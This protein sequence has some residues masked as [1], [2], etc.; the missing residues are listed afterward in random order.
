MKK[1]YEHD[2]KEMS[3]VIWICRP[4]GD[5]IVDVAVFLKKKS[6]SKATIYNNIYFKRRP[7]I[8]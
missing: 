7:P 6:E 1:K 2:R 5:G 4:G 3:E 8:T